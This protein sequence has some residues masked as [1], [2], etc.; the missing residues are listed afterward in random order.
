MALHGFRGVSLG[1]AGVFALIL[2]PTL[3]LSLPI[4]D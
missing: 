1:D 3:I 4:K 2:Q